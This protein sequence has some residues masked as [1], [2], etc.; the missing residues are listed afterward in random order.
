MAVINGSSFDGNILSYRA[1]I[2][3]F[4]N[5]PTD[6]SGSTWSFGFT[7]VPRQNTEDPLMWNS[8]P[9]YIYPDFG[10][11][12]GRV[13]SVSDTSGVVSVDAET[14][15]FTLNS[16]VTIPPFVGTLADSVRRLF[17]LVGMS[18]DQVQVYG[19]SGPSVVC[20]GFRGSVWLYLKYMAD[21]YK[22]RLVPD[23]AP[24]DVNLYLSPNTKV[25]TTNLTSKTRDVRNVKSSRAVEVVRYDNKQITNSTV[26]PSGPLL[27]AQVI[28]VTAGETVTVSLQLDAWLSSVNQ[29]VPVNSLAGDP[30]TID[31]NYYDG[32]SGVYV[33]SG[34]DGLN[35]PASQWTAQGGR[36]TVSITD[37]PSV[38][39]VT[40]IS[41]PATNSISSYS[42]SMMSGTNVAYNALFLT[43]TG[44]TFSKTSRVFNT[45]A[46]SALTGQEVGY[47][48]DNPFCS[49]A[50]ILNDLGYRAA[51]GYNG[52]QSSMSV[53]VVNMGGYGEIPGSQIRE[54]EAYY[55]VES[56]SLSESGANLTARMYSPVGEFN[57]RW[58]GE[59]VAD[60]NARW[61]GK[62]AG[63]MAVAPLRRP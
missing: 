41:P 60:F 6:T 50:S 22:F 12:S 42:I 5:D 1:D 11:I 8:K 57:A 31:P 52:I 24:G 20:P 9:V 45:G 23:A 35:V 38:V 26:F 36:L 32:T 47:T 63:D 13:S 53:G 33:V 14:V 37:D 30:I 17:P 40:V 25:V 59:T 4:S 7:G 44:V 29:P 28:Q 55:T 2:S 10:A 49:S 48:V 58:A 61:A 34:S 15:M 27:D 56:A 18:E 21:V 62:T 54:A 51:C 3:G 19:G 46:S 43:G 16:E 39:E